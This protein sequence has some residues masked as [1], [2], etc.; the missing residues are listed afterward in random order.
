MIKTLKGG[1][2]QWTS[3][4]FSSALPP[5]SLSP[6]TAQKLWGAFAGPGLK[7][8]AGFVESLGFKPGRP[9]AWVL[10]LAEAAGGLSLAAGFLTPFGAMAMIAVMVVA[11][12]A[13]HADKGF[14]ATNGG[15][16]HPLLLAVAAAGVAFAG[17]GAYSLDAALDWSLN[18]TA[19]G[20]AAVMVGSLA[21]A[22]VLVARELAQRRTAP[23]TRSA[24]SRA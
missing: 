14:F 11:I 24:P 4:C 23:G 12:M 17:P 6:L 20:W 19:W 7:G 22:A 15:Y 21:S 18:G 2:A 8:T 1:D 16:E 10:G 9:Y 5:G 13:V 3:V